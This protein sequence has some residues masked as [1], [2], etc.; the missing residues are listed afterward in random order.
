MKARH[1]AAPD[2]R[3]YRTVPRVNPGAVIDTD[4]RLTIYTCGTCGGTVIPVWRHGAVS[5][6]RHTPSLD[7]VAS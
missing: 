3:T 5:H 1:T 7:W 2:P 4:D 6:Y